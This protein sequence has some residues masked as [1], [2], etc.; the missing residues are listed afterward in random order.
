MT[1]A[2]AHRSVAQTKI[3]MSY[4]EYLD[5]ASESRIVE[6]VNGEVIV[7]MPPVIDHQD[8][9]GFLFS[10]IRLFV[11]F[12]A[13]GTVLLA[14][15]EVKLWPDGPSREPDLLFIQQNSTTKITDKRIVGAPE[16]IVEVVSPSSVTIDRVHK[17]TEYEQAGVREYWIIDPRPH[18][19]QADFFERNADGDFVPVTL[20]ANGRFYSTLLPHFWLDVAWLWQSP[21]P[22]P[23]LI[24]SQI[25]L[26]T[27]ELLP[28]TKSTFQRL[29]QLLS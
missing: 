12:N 4:A 3:K 6:W 19:Q 16:L 29:Y 22:N 28:E 11:D 18:Q 26:D 20:D 15:L 2:V 17:F 1:T 24:F 8:I 10:I 23:Q 14:P 25:M 13:L 7:H 9:V 27:P 21:H 5:F